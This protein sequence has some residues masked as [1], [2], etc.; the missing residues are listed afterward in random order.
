MKVKLVLLVVLLCVT[1]LTLPAYGQ[2]PT[3]ADYNKITFQQQGDSL[4]VAIQFKGPIAAKGDTLH[5]G[6][7][8]YVDYDDDAA[9]GQQGSS[10]VGSECNLTFCDWDGDNTWCMRVYGLWNNSIGTFVISGMMPVNISPDGLTMSFTHSLVGLGLEDVAYDANGYWLSGTNWWN[11]P[12]NVGGAPDSIG[13]YSF[14]PSLVPAIDTTVAGSRSKLIIPAYYKNKAQTLNITAALDE[15]VNTVE[16]ELGAISPTRPYTLRYNPYTNYSAFPYIGAPNNQFTTYIP[17]SGWD[18]L[19]TPDWWA[20]IEG[21]VDMTMRERS[22]GFREFFATSMNTDIPLPNTPDGWYSTRMDSTHGFMWKVDHVPTFKAILGR[23]LHNLITIY[24]GEKLSSTGTHAAAVAARTQAANAYASFSGNATDLDPWI[25]TGFLL[26]KIG[27]NVDWTKTLYQT[28]PLTF[29]APGDAFGD[30]ALAVL[31]NGFEDG[32]KPYESR[33]QWYQN[34]ASTQAGAID[35]ITGGDIYTQ[36]K[37][38]SGYP[39]KDS[40][41]TAAKALMQSLV[42]V[43]DRPNGL[44][45][46]FKVFQN[47]PNPFNPS[48]KIVFMIP[49]RALTTVRVYDIIGREVGTLL[50][51]NLEPGRY[52]VNWNAKELSSGLYFYRIESGKFVAVKKAVLLK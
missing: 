47:Y 46:V 12:Y 7:T 45:R 29:S 14:N 43:Q 13:L 37:A 28:L 21:A 22:Q 16:S 6:N 36:L 51:A 27:S 30:F 42:S 31:R 44:P 23:A 15:I 3:W 32:T 17:K 10:R 25:M 34:I 52:E 8:V 50:Q 9:T 2:L 18:T 40:V 5:A 49:E 24:I 19:G 41:Y 33:K 39:T 48:T 11:D 26:S 20:M 35:A 1:G 4:Y 38:I